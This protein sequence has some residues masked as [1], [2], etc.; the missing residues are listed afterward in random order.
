MKRDVAE[1]TDDEGLR[2]LAARS[3][4]VLVWGSVNADPQGRLINY[5]SS[6]FAAARVSIVIDE[7]D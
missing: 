4:P 1:F 6:V 7:E 3:G 2:R 5:D